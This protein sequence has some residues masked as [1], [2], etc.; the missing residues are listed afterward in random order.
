MI[1]DKWQVLGITALIFNPV[2]TGILAGYFLHR[3]KYGSGK[4]IML[5]SV[6][7]AAALIYFLYARS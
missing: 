3:D 4:F 2:P 1:L 5:L 6:I 7:W